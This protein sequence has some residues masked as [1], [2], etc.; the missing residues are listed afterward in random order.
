AGGD[1]G[2]VSAIFE[3]HRTER[4]VLAQR[5]AWVGAETPAARTFLDFLRNQR[6]RSVEADVEHFVAGFKARIGLLMAHERSE[7]AKTGGDRL[8][9]FGVPTDLARQ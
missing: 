5:L 8:A 9:G 3:R 1:I 7:T 6:D 2:A 4:R